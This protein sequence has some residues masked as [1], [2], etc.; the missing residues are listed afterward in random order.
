MDGAGIGARRRAAPVQ[1]PSRR[2]AT[3][4]C[5]T[6]SG[7]GSFH[8]VNATQEVLPTLVEL[9]PGEER[10]LQQTLQFEAAL[11]GLLPL[12]AG[13][14]AVWLDG[15][16][17]VHDTEAGARAWATASLASDSGRVIARIADRSPVALSGLT[18]F[19]YTP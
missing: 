4:G 16:R 15:L 13:R 6:P 11:P 18:A 12:H 1:G 5:E 14:W 9:T 7:R 8:G 3:L 19:Q 2:A 17:S 10:T